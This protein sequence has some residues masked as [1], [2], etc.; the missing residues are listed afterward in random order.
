MERI[1]HLIQ[2]NNPR[3]KRCFQN[4]RS[5]QIFSAMDEKRS[6]LGPSRGK[7]TEHW[8]QIQPRAFRDLKN[9]RGR[10]ERVNKGG[11]KKRK[12]KHIHIGYIHYMRNQNGYKSSKAIRKLKGNRANH[13]IIQFLI[14]T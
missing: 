2:E 10:K 8:K 3:I 1:N 6:T 9:E 4:E 7:I 13:K 12:T 14:F 5:H 11:G